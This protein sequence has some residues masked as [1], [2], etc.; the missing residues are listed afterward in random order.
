MHGMTA[1][2]VVQ[3]DGG[4][5]LIGLDDTGRVWYGRPQQAG[6][7]WTIK[8]SQFEEHLSVAH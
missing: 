4:W 7:R 2:E 5:F 1:I 3:A 8:W 6:E